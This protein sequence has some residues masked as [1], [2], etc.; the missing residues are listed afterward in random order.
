MTT[1]YHLLI[2]VTLT[3]ALGIALGTFQRYQGDQSKVLERRLS[4]ASLAQTRLALVE[5]TLRTFIKVCDLHLTNESAFTHPSPREGHQKSK[6]VVDQLEEQVF[7]RQHKELIQTINICL[8]EFQPMLRNPVFS[9]PEQGKAAAESKTEKGNATNYVVTEVNFSDPQPDPNAPPTRFDLNEYDRLTERIREA[10]LQLGNRIDEDHAILAQAALTVDQRNHYLFMG[11][12]VVFA[13]ISTLLL[14]WVRNQIATPITSIAESAQEAIGNHLPF[15]DI[16]QGTP[17]IRNLSGTLRNLINQHEELVT[18]RTKELVA[19]TDSLKTELA[20]RDKAEEGL[21]TAIEKAESSSQAKSAF[22]AMM[23]HEIRTPMNGVV[24]CS[25]LL[26]DTTLSQ[27]QREYAETIRDSTESLLRIVNDILDFSKIE[28]GKLDFE[29]EPFSPEKTIEHAVSLL[30]PKAAEKN[31]EFTFE[32]VSSLPE[33]F[34]G[35]EVRF[36]QIVLNL[37]GNAVKFTLAGHV[38]VTLSGEPLEE[39]N[40]DHQMWRIDFS[41]RDSGEGIPEEVL[42]YLFNPFSQADN[43][44]ARRFGGT[45]LGLAISQRLVKRMGGEISTESVVGEGTT[46][47]FFVLLPEAS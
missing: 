38:E 12:L 39:L 30:R 22:V 7:T 15:Q 3:T 27:L 25:D 11:S 16:S 41:V 46:F 19:Q 40:G 34:L 31:L 42:P 44:V 35:D 43:S 33:L 9:N 23:S 2:V 10:F 45:G 17:E 47:H 6:R 24:G 28:S 5:D 32:V 21:R 20:R 14:R 4:Q 13:L 26:L 1:R 29:A 36:K 8:R 37:V 18:E